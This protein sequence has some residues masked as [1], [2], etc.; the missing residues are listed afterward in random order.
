MCFEFLREIF[1]RKPEN[2][3]SFAAVFFTNEKLAEHINKKM[4]AKDTE[5]TPPDLD[6]V[7]DV[8]PMK[9]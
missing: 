1:H 4:E 6:F 7:L 3:Y 2:F 9:L 8:T 5:Q